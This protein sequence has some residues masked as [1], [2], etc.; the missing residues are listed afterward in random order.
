MNRYIDINK[1]YTREEA[2]AVLLKLVNA[3]QLALKKTFNM[4]NYKYEG[5]ITGQELYNF[6]LDQSKRGLITRGGMYDLRERDFF[7]NSGP[8]NFSNVVRPKVV[9]QEQKESIIV[10]DIDMEVVT[11]PISPLS[12]DK[13]LDK[14]I[15]EKEQYLEELKKEIFKAQQK[16]MEIHDTIGKVIRNI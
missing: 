11:P 15:V 2:K 16:L 6:I 12:T 5:D 14:E 7:Q 10:E 9:Y 13:Y 1:V 3:K 8:P 4:N